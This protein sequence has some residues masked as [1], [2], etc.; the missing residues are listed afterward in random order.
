M[1]LNILQTLGAQS[2]GESFVTYT[3]PT[4]IYRQTKYPTHKYITAC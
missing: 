2:Y 1:V 3:P 4:I